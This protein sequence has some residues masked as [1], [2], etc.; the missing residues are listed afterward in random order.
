MS[1]YWRTKVLL[2]FAPYWYDICQNT[3]LFSNSF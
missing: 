2:R 3:C 1:V